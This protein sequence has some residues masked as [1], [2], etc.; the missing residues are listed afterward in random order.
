MHISQ[1][2][3]DTRFIIAPHVPEMGCSEC[4]GRLP[5]KKAMADRPMEN[6]IDR[7]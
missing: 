1:Y 6:F 5:M 4:F 7:H 3:F 2:V